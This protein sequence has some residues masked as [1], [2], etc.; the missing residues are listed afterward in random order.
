MGTSVSEKPSA[1]GSLNKT[2]YKKILK[3][4]GI[5][6]SGAVLTYVLEILPGI[7]FGQYT[8]IVAPTLSVLI[9][10]VLKFIQGPK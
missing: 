2:D 7:D 5:A 1:Q 10:A 3:G 6:A 9:N 8:L 4:A